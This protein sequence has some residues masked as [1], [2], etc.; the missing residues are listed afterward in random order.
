MTLANPRSHAP[1]PLRA[2][3]AALT[4]FTALLLGALREHRPRAD[5]VEQRRRRDADSDAGVDAAPATSTP[6]PSSVQASSPA[7]PVSRARW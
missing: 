4:L 6:G 3:S 5:D 1:A 2:A 7:T